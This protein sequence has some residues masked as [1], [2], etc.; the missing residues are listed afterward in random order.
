MNP[1]I[2]S[3]E[4]EIPP[5]AVDEA[6]IRP[7][8]T[9]TTVLRSIRTKNHHV[10]VVE[11]DVPLSK[12]LSREFKLM[13]FAVD[14][15]HD[16]E[17]AY[18]NIRSST[19]DLVILDLNLPNMDGITFLQR[20]RTSVEV[21]IPVLVLT[22]RSR[23]EDMIY[24]LDQG[25]DDCLIKPF[26]FQELQARVRSLL[27]RNFTP[28]ATS[29][30]VGDLILNKEERRVMRGQRRIELTPREF[31]ILECLMNNMGKPVSRMSLMKEV[32]NIAFDPT[33]NIVDV[34]MK[35]LRDKI[36]G[37]GETK[38]IRTV[39]GIGYELRND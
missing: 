10:L 25:A 5:L 23:T 36:D 27:R 35:Y 4:I 15:S 26:S 17:S 30:K 9:H 34:Y 22:A 12:F 38:L 32:W 37:E 24:A 31:S 2:L 28:A 3:S 21:H 7:P 18:E 20:I 13:H 39:R 8:A 16:A 1:S 29:A 19:Y 6:A 33:T 11:D 14:V